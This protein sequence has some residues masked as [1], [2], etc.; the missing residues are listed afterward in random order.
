MAD[1]QGADGEVAM[2]SR[3][4]FRT[5]EWFVLVATAVLNIANSSQNWVSW[6]DALLP[7]ITA[8]GYIVSRGLAKT[9]PRPAV[10]TPTPP[11]PPAA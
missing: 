3:P 11:A 7:T 1:G 9:E 5:S 10:P 4:G 6:R 2:L 8:A